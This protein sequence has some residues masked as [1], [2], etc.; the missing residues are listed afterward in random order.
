M[1]RETIKTGL[2]TWAR[3]LNE[4]DAIRGSEG[5]LWFQSKDAAGKATREAQ[6]AQAEAPDY[7]ISLREAKAA[8]LL[9]I[10][11]ATVELDRLPRYPA[12]KGKMVLLEEVTAWL[13]RNGYGHQCAMTI[14]EYFKD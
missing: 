14:N 13:Y 6:K 11:R 8:L 3:K 5:V 7:L 2:I 4:F 9:G 10:G 1:D 12:P